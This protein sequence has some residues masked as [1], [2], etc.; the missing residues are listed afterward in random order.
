MASHNLRRLLS[1][2]YLYTHT[3]T[4]SAPTLTRVTPAAS[5]LREVLDASWWQRG[6]NVRGVWGWGAAEA[7]M[8]AAG[9]LPLMAH[10]HAAAA[11]AAAGPAAAA[12][13]AALRKYPTLPSEALM[14][15]IAALSRPGSGELRAA[16]AAVAITAAAT[17]AGGGGGGVRTEGVWDGGGEGEAGGGG[18]GSEA[19]VGA[20]S[21]SRLAG[22]V[23][24]SLLP[25]G[26]LL[27]L[28]AVDD[29]GVRLRILWW[30]GGAGMSVCVCVRVGCG[31]GG[32]G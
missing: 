19:G 28:T 11:A 7:K 4:C 8:A 22:S 24:S 13:L 26:L 3:S 30:V 18:P 9:L 1:C 5:E 2:R 16:A 14:A 10:P 6:G 20:P 23:G 25:A 12:A 31:V 17:R 15:G 29:D 27:P 32:G 21:S